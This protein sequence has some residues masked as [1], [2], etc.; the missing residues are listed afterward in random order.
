MTD[1]GRYKF[2]QAL[3]MMQNGTWMRPCEGRVGLCWKM[4]D[5]KWI[6]SN[7]GF[8]QYFDKEVAM[9]FRIEEVLGEWEKAN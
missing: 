8:Q 7:P 1:E 9:Y 3:V 4:F 5:G 2:E 6:K